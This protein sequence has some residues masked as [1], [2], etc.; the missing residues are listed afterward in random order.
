MII[1]T[2]SLYPVSRCDTV[3]AEMFEPFTRLLAGE[4]VLRR[5]PWLTIHAHTYLHHLISKATPYSLQ[6]HTFDH[7]NPKT[8]ESTEVQQR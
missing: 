6:S 1:M 2:G 4:T 7:L 5:L 3:W 8:K